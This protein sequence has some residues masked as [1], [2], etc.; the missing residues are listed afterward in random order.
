MAAGDTKARSIIS[1]SYS[2]VILYLPCLPNKRIATDDDPPP[3]TAFSH[4]PEGL[5][6]AGFGGR[7]DFALTL[8]SL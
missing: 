4:D 8:Q 1:L 6:L 5:N 7:D 3:P 2:A